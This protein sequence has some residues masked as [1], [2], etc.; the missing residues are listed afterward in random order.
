MILAF[1]SLGSCGPIKSQDVGYSVDIKHDNYYKG[2]SGYGGYGY[3]GQG[4]SGSQGYVVGQGVSGGYK[5]NGIYDKQIEKYHYPKYSF[6]YGVKDLHTGDIKDQWEHRDGDKVKGGYMLKEADGTMRIVEYTA[7]DH[8]GF[9]AVVKNIG[10]ATHDVK[11][12]EAKVYNI[13]AVG[14][15]FGPQGALDGGL[16]SGGKGSS[17][18]AQSYVNFEKHA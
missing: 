8:N 2:G 11:A 17:K 16:G 4:G 18:H 10:Q 5:K 15:G 9:N 14:P 13:G 7:D 1:P 3:G 12:Y 6:Q